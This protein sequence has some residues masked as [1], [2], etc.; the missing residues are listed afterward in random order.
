MYGLQFMFNSRATLLVLQTIDALLLTTLYKTMSRM[1]K[2]GVKKVIVI[3]WIYV[4]QVQT[5]SKGETV[6]VVSIQN[7]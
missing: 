2:R 5:V 1:A 3:T 6:T 4:I 7:V